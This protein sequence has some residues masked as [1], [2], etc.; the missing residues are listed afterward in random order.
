MAQ[1]LCR[2]YAGLRM[3][4][5]GALSQ[6][7]KHM[8]NSDGRR[9][10]NVK[11]GLRLTSFWN[12]LPI[13]ALVVF[14]T[15]FVR[16]IATLDPLQIWGA[17]A[18][19]EVWQW[20]SACVFTALSFRAIGTYDVLV[21]KVLN[22]RQPAH[23]ARGAGVKAIALSQTLGFGAITSA[24]VRW[25]CLPHLPAVQIAR[26]SATV[27][28]SF[29][30]GLAA[31]AGLVIPLSGLMAWSW[32]FALVGIVAVLALALLGKLAYRSG[33]IPSPLRRRTLLAL[34]LATAADTAFAAAALWMLWPEAISFHLLF[35]AYLVALGAGLMS[36]T[37]GGV[38]AFDL[39][40]LALVP[41]NDDAATMAAILAFRVIYYALPATLALVSL[42]RPMPMASHAPLQHDEAALA[43]QD[44]IVQHHP[45]GP[46]LT[47]PA[48]G[49]GAVMGDLPRGMT[50]ADLNSP[51]P[52]AIYKCSALQAAQARRAGWAVLRCARD[53]IISLD[54]WTIL[55][56][57]RR[58]L[59]RA[60]RFFAGSGLTIREIR[61]FDRLRP[62]AES[63]AKDHGGE[64]GLS[65]GRF[66]ETYLRRQRVFAAFDHQRPIAFVSFHHG[67]RWTLDLMRHGRDV[68]TGTMQALICA[69][70]DA[71]RADGATSLSLSSVPAPEPHFPYAKR[72]VQDAAGLVRFKS[73]FAPDWQPRYICGRTHVHLFA[74]MV[75]LAFGILRPAP[76]A[77]PHSVHPDNED[78]SFAPLPASCEP[79]LT[80]DGA[81]S[82]DKR[83]FRPSLSA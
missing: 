3:G 23:L 8:M 75:T 38:G 74:T 24:L 16:H 60:L 57:E 72:A 27:S 46:L 37:P 51:H 11:L 44:A 12:V 22:T 25:R 52:K 69:A 34:L 1:D 10:G 71:A 68:P 13:V 14:G 30:V 41:V 5:T 78:Y 81:F 48:F 19:L 82:N 83:P 39:T 29:L 15:L 73:A 65:M 35:A 9:I 31:V 42:L 17:F 40:L 53:A 49:A 67:P 36:N 32:P 64:R 26:L 20:A 2:L 45:K 66:C 62:I 21:H 33:W 28:L 63:W 58:Q 47:L 6:W 80:H 55:G 18:A 79:L 7:A 59:R 43:M 77:R 76:L 61:H 70:I 50:I 54:D 4:R 56:P